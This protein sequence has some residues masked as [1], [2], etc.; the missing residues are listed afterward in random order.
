MVNPRVKGIKP[1]PKALEAPVLSL[2]YTPDLGRLVAPSAK[3]SETKP[4]HT[5]LKPV[6]SCATGRRSIPELMVQPLSIPDKV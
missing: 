4:D 2:N 3:P 6:A 5:G 1:L